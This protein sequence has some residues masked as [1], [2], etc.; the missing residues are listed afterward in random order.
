MKSILLRALLLLGIAINVGF[1]LINLS[2]DRPHLARKQKV[3]VLVRASPWRIAWMKQNMFDEF[4]AAHDLDIELVEARDFV[5]AASLIIA[6]KDHPT[7]MLLADVNDELS[8]KVHDAHAAVAAQDY[9]SADELTATL[10]DYSPEAI[11]R[12]KVDGKLWFIPKRALVDVAAFLRPAV[13][14]LYLHWEGDRPAIEAA[15]KEA[16]GVGFPKSYQ[17]EK[18][19]EG[20]DSFD[21]FVAGWYWAHHPAKWASP[22]DTAPAPR[23]AIRTGLNDDA[24]DDLFG[25]FY[26]HGFKADQLAALDAPAVLDALQWRALFRRYHL[27]A[28]IDEQ[29]GSVDGSAINDLLK[30]RKVAWAPIDQ[31]DSL[32]VHGGARRDA[33]PGMVGAVDLDWATTP[34]GSSAEIDPKTGEAARQGQ[35][36]SLEEVHFWAIPVHA[37]DP[38]LAFQLARYL[39][40]RG[41]HQRETE[42]VGLLPVR[43]DLAQDYPILFRLDWMQRMLDAS[44]RQLT[45]GS[46]DM[47]DDIAAK[48]YDKV[49][50]D[51]VAA[52]LDGMPPVTL[53]GVR[54]RVEQFKSNRKLAEANHVQ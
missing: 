5:E 32:W 51:L 4:A 46:G 17:L 37:P 34:V 24:L 38:R 3:R 53:A 16:N 25:A 22:G 44:Y 18:T 10:A 41:L 9:A 48:G 11:L 35:S 21:L 2:P 33:E 26:R 49:Y 13:E 20:W 47:P 45:R 15:L 14:D 43:V 28:A 6:E 50:T 54:E 52:V 8:D 23:M 7:G 30:A 19:P 36:F 31:A 27:L 40:Q 29:P 1:L 39:T 42:A 12:A